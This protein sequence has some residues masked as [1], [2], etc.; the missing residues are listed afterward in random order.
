LYSIDISNPLYYFIG[1][2]LPL[3]IVK[4]R[5]RIVHLINVI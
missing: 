5:R 4:D 3:Y 1:E 2:Y